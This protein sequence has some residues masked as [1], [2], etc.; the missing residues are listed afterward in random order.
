MQS[1]LLVQCELTMPL[2]KQLKEC[3]KRETEGLKRSK[4]AV[5]MSQ[6]KAKTPRKVTRGEDSSCK[7]GEGE[8]TGLGEERSDDQGGLKGSHN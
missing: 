3:G 4:E 6:R 1:N 5:E 2:K 7:V 8:R